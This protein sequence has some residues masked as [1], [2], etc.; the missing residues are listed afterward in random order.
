MLSPAIEALLILQDRDTRRLGLE[1]QL[2]A[3]PGEI[4]RVEQT[5]AAENAALEDSKTELRSLET[6]KKGIETEIG[7]AETKLGKYRTQQLA[8]RKND[9]F[10]AL[11][12]EIDTTA[13]QIGDLEGRELEVMYAIDEAKKKFAAAE[14]VMKQNISGHEARIRTMREREGNVA[15]E[16]KTAQ[17]EVATSRVAGRRQL[18]AGLRPDGGAR[19]AGRGREPGQQMR[20]LPSQDFERG[21]V[22]GPRQRLPRR[23]GAL[24]PM[25]ADCVLGRL[26]E[27]ACLWP[28]QNHPLPSLALGLGCRSR[29]FD[30][31]ARLN[32][33]SAVTWRGKSGHH[34]AGCCA[35]RKASAGAAVQAAVTDS[36]TENIPPGGPHGTPGKGEKVG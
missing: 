18:A 20:R 16:L 29:F 27:Q 14:A 1:A 28:S 21:R 30:P 17:A 35:S 22:G 26:G 5:I 2:K 31:K 24:R 33:T 7:S 15:T 4:A 23:I 36:V 19:D 8:V 9:E 25:R 6:R 3:V 10:Q 32:S 11:G 34:R 12:H 13:A